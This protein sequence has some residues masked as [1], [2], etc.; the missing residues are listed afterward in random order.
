MKKT[1]VFFTIMLVIL[2]HSVPA[3]AR[4]GQ[5]SSGTGPRS[6]RLANGACGIAEPWWTSKW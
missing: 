5:S 4:G 1:V 2:A 6:G 3:F